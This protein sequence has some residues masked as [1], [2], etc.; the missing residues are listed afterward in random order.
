LSHKKSKGKPIILST[1]LSTSEQVKKA[2]E[3]LGTD[4]LVILH[5]VSTY[6]TNDEDLNLRHIQTL[7]REY[8]DVPV[9]YS[10]HEHGTT[11]SV[12]ATVLGAVLVERHITLDRSMW[13]SDQSASLEPAGLKLMVGNI[14]R[15]EKALGTGWGS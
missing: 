10:G 12:C 14:R 1:G 15:I 3:I 5:C 8:P 11:V 13:G 2:V 4:N 7:K 9:G 6:P